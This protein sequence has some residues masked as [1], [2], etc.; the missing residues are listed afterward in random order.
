MK[1]LHSIII[2]S[3]IFWTWIPCSAQ[4]KSKAEIFT[5]VKNNFEKMYPGAEIKEWE[6][7]EN[8]IYEVEFTFN[9]LKY[10]A[11]YTQDGTWLFTERDIETNEIPAPV[12]QSLKASEWA[13]WKIDEVE[14]LSAPRQ[15][16]YYEI[17]LNQNGQEVYLYYNPDG[18]LIEH[19]AKS[20]Y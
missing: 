1:I 5:V 2:I 12:L 4:E 9:G 7:E 18:T 19:A 8:N 20:K 11:E 17:E 13:S 6:L 3:I 15:E 10:E 16:K 14:E